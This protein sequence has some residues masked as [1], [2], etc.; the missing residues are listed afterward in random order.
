MRK[1]FSEFLDKELDKRRKDAFEAH[2]EGC[3]T[4]RA[5][6]DEFEKNCAVIDGSLKQ[7]AGEIVPAKDL[8]ERTLALVETYSHLARKPTLRLAHAALAACLIVV[9]FVGRMYLHEKKFAKRLEQRVSLQEQAVA[10]AGKRIDDLVEEMDDAKIRHAIG[11]KN[12]KRDFTAMLKKNDVVLS[13]EKNRMYRDLFVDN[14]VFRKKEPL[15][16]PTT[17][18][19][20][21]RNQD[22]S[23]LLNGLGGDIVQF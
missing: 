21:R 19:R 17:L 3:G 7:A 20:L 18:W 6:L 8:E 13:Y 4:C 5:A 16:S 22:L 1:L 15:R 11:I 23:D 14:D 2:L 10:A 12:L 9:V